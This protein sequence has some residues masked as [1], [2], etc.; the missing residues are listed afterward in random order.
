[1]RPRFELQLPVT[2]E[3]WLDALRSAL[4]NDAQSLRGQVFRKHAVVQMR[5]TERTFWSPYLS[6]EVEDEPDGSA[7]RGRFSPHPNVWTMFMA[8]YILLAIVALGGLSYGMVQYTLGQSPWSF[9][10][11]PAAVALFG[12]VYGATLIGQGLGAEQMYTM[13]SL[14]DRVCMDALGAPEDRPATVTG[15]AR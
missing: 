3:A 12:F 14:V 6:L 2:R 1:M 15:Q 8:I 10:I 7:V 11:A 13:R 4:Q 5:D 9:L